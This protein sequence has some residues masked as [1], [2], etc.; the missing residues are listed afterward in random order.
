[1]RRRGDLRNDRRCGFAL[2]TARDLDALGGAA[3][4]VAEIR[5]RVGGGSKVYV[6]VDVDVLDPAYAPATGTPEPGGWTSRELLT[7]LDGLMGL[8][9]V[10]ADVVEVA[11]VYDNAGETTALVAAEVAMSLLALMVGRPVKSVADGE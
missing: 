7:V 9:V 1:M 11:P 3:G 8:Q 10:G 4:V 5:R 6:T 2:V